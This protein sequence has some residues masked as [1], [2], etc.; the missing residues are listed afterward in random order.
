MHIALTSSFAFSVRPRRYQSRSLSP[1]SCSLALSLSLP[2]AVHPT[3][4]LF[5]CLTRW[6]SL[7]FQITSH[8]SRL[9]SRTL[10]HPLTFSHIFGIICLYSRYNATPARVPICGSV[11][12]GGRFRATDSQPFVEILHG[13][14]RHAFG[15]A[16]E[17]NI[18]LSMTK[19]TQWSL[20]NN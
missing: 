4:S 5:P 20:L 15:A 11:S 7:S 8:L 6:V 2:L 3:W 9:F 12:F 16:R 10:S 17:P 13:Y 19:T 1:V 18:L 14:R